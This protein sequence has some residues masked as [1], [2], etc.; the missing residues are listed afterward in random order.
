MFDT[1]NVFEFCLS[2]SLGLMTV[3]NMLLSKSV[4]LKRPTPQAISNQ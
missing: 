2:I 3:R 1:T 4:D